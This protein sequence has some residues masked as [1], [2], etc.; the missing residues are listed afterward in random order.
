MGFQ[1]TKYYPMV[2]VPEE[3]VSVLE[4]G[5]YDE[6]VV[7]PEPIM[8]ER[9]NRPW[10]PLET[11][12]KSMKEFQWL[13]VIGFPFMVLGVGLWTIPYALSVFIGLMVIV[14][15]IDDFGY[16]WDQFVYWEVIV[17]LPL[18]L[19][20]SLVLTFLGTDWVKTK[21]YKEPKPND[22]LKAEQKEYEKRKGEYE[23]KCVEIRVRNE[24]KMKDFEASYADK[25]YWAKVSKFEEIVAPEVSTVDSSDHVKR[26]T[27]EAYFEKFLRKEF[28]DCIK[29][30]QVTEDQVFYPDFVYVCP[31]SGIHI[32]IE[33]DEP[34]TL[35][36]GKPIHYIG[37]G[38]ED[39]ND[40]FIRNNWCVVRFTEE[41][42]LQEPD[43]CTNLLKELV[44]ELVFDTDENRGQVYVSINSTYRQKRW[45]KKKAKKWAKK[46]YREEDLLEAGLI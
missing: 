5:I 27:S 33:I 45:K 24:Q 9:P 13:S 10:R 17:I 29:I 35:K 30:N 3:I 43:E 4:N 2:L 31:D 40:Y 16:Q 34:Y 19:I 20:I 44:N 12:S 38:D 25:L 46:N 1:D 14:G 32:D 28:D 41:Q 7:I 22:E 23:R 36:K 6:D 26:G 39:R 15:W 21:H 11:V 42:V 8:E 18:W 37:C